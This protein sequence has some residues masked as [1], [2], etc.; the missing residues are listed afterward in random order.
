MSWRLAALLLRNHE[1]VNGCCYEAQALS[2]RISRVTT[3]HCLSSKSGNLLHPCRLRLFCA[4]DLSGTFTTSNGSSKSD[5]CRAAREAAG[6]TVIA[7]RYKHSN[8]KN[9]VVKKISECMKKLVS[10]NPNVNNRGGY[11]DDDG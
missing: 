9:K 3:L 2:F 10:S 8:F 5:V 7:A 4:T 11:D 6:H 1:Q